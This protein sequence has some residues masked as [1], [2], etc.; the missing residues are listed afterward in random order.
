[1]TPVNV[2]HHLSVDRNPVMP[3][4]RPEPGAG[5][6]GHPEGVPLGLHR[7]C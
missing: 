4:D 6:A 5:A 2:M 3:E 7:P 1:M